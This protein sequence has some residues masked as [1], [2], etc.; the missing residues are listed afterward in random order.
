ML[1]QPLTN[2]YQKRDTHRL[3]TKN[4]TKPHPTHQE[5]NNTNTKT[6]TTLPTS[7]YLPNNTM[8]YKTSGSRRFMSCPTTNQKTYQYTTT[9]SETTITHTRKQQGTNLCNTKYR[10]PVRPI[11]VITNCPPSPRL[12]S[13]HPSHY[14]Y[15]TKATNNIY[16]PLTTTKRNITTNTNKRPI[17]RRSNTRHFTNNT[18][19][20]LTR[21]C[22]TKR[23]K[24]TYAPMQSTTTTRPTRLH[25]PT[26]L[27]YRVNATLLP[28]IHLN[29]NIPPKTTFIHLTKKRPATTKTTTKSNTTTPKRP[30]QRR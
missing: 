9:N 17:L 28:N 25:Q 22:P 19:R 23:P 20:H 18:L 27:S 1:Q 16:H 13:E 8:P 10:Q 26:P 12:H 24:Q 4:T 15:T 21:Q 3:T 6:T 14:P 29:E 5:S 30:H 11:F 2:K 7:Q